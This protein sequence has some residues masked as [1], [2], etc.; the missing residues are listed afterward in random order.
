MGDTGDELP[1]GESTDLGPHAQNKGCVGTKT[2]HMPSFMLTV[3]C[4]LRVCVPQCQ[5]HFW[6]THV[7]NGL[8]QVATLRDYATTLF[9]SV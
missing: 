3:G 5:L 9:T 8:S 7:S 6:R 2:L 4:I 1:G